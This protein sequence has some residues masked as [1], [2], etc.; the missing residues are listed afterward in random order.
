MPR[1]KSILAILFADVAK[2]THL[3]EKLGN[4]AAQSLIGRCITVM[5]RVTAGYN[6]TVIKTI[7][8]EIM[9]TF[10]SAQEAVDAGKDMQLALEDIPVPEQ[11][12]FPPP[13][14][15]VGIQY[16]PV[17]SEAGDVFGDAVNVAARMV[18]M[19]KQRQIITTQETVDALPP[20]YKEELRCIDKTTVKGKSGELLIYEVIWEQHD[21][22]I[23]LDD[24]PDAAPLLKLSLELT[25]AGST[26][27]VD[28]IHPMAMLGRQVHNDVVVNDTRVSRSHA[29]VEYRKG[30]FILVDQ[31]TNGTY[32]VIQKKKNLHLRRDETTLLGTGIIGLGREVTDDS[33]AAIHYAIKM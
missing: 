7:G 1:E 21:V 30:K 6:G 17:I 14:I 4:T 23:M 5:S 28:D 19:A 22:T 18:G 3:Y 15:Y 10:P 11:P 27:A 25:F 12:G 32:V 33:P 9:C 24:S 16:G 29:R 2:S 20:Q 26:V 31:S 8:D 13:N